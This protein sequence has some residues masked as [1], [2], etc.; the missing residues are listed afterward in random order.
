MMLFLWLTCSAVE[1]PGLALYPGLAAIQNPRVP[2][3][4]ESVPDADRLEPNLTLEPAIPFQWVWEVGE[5]IRLN[6]AASAPAAGDCAVLTA[7][8]WE[9]RPVAQ[10]RFRIPF[11]ETVEVQV[12]GRGTY[13][14]SLD[15]LEGNRCVARKVRSFSVCPSNLPRRTAW[16]AEEFFVGTC[17]FP[18]RQHWRNE[19]GMATPPG[20][21]QQA[22]RE[23]DA[24]LSARLGVQ[25]VRPDLPVEWASEEAPLNFTK[26]DTALGA[27]T[28][29]G[30]RLD[31]QLGLPGD[32]AILPEYA[33]VSDPKWRYPKR[34]GPSRRY[35]AECVKRYGPHAAFIELYNEPDIRDFWRG[36]PEQYV[37]WARWAVEEIRRV[38]PQAMVVNGGYSFNQPELT[39]F[40]ARELRDW[41]DGVAYHAHG[42]LRNLKDR[43]DT[44]RAVQA[45]LGRENP[46]FFNTEMGYTAWRLDM[47]RTQA[48]T[49]VQKV[50]YCWAHRH[51]GALLYCSRDV[52]G[53]RL[54]PDD[55]DWGYL[56]YFFCPRFMYGAVA[57]LID[58]YAGAHF[59]RVLKET[60][61]LHAYLFRAEGKRLVAAFVPYDGKQSLTLESDASAVQIVDPMGNATPVPPGRVRLDVAFYPQTVVLEGATTVQTVEEP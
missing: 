40:F 55:P 34:E 9:V 25:V 31:L 54:R 36:R 41:I 53:P 18:G 3:L 51:R 24:E 58:G 2:R 30:F 38:A 56:D 17:A 20:L 12:Q 43:F 45:A 19:F 23:L 39:G 7:W 28:S 47:E 27:W 15:L 42:D 50:L 60:D 33:D 61:H 59:E 52:G 35:V 26:A 57:A 49:A 46:I 14:L 29:R 5:P 8:D 37:E 21:S 44:M 16:A 13:L 10:L 11:D 48:A 1:G 6:V 4:Y 32:W 22:S